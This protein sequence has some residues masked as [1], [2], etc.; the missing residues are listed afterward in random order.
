[1]DQGP[2]PQKRVLVVEDEP[3][4]AAL[5]VELLEAEGVAPVKVGTAAEALALLA[6]RRFD[7]VI[8]DIGLPDMSGL[9][10]LERLPPEPLGPRVMVMT[11]D[12]EPETLLQAVRGHVHRYLAKPV[13]ADAFRE[14]VRAALAAPYEPPIE[15]LS[16]TPQWIELLVPCTRGAAERIQDLLGQLDTRLTPAVSETVGSVFRELLLNAVEWGGGLD[17]QRRVRVACLRTARMLQ[18]RIADPG[19][20]FKLDS[21]AH[22]AVNNPPEDPIRHHRVREQAGLRPGGLGML[23]A[24]SLADELVYNEA[25][26]EVVFIKYLVQD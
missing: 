10:V 16:A 12:R 21:L 5:A 9:T 1:M 23:M 6:E 15:V 25:R 4:L 19:P 14:A 3:V 8:L 17:P 11:A 24:S 13:R 22:A 2:P 26:N 7:L 18:Y 20:G